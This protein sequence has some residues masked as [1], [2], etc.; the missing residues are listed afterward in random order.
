MPRALLLVAHIVLL[1]CLLTGAGCAG[2]ST[3]PQ[4]PASSQPRLRVRANLLNLLACPNVNCDVIEDLHSS[5][6]VA[7]LSPI[8]NGWIMVRVPA[9]GHEGYVEAKFLDR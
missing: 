6:E 3:E 8:M 1:A 9:T 2:R 7:A 5:Q 4:A